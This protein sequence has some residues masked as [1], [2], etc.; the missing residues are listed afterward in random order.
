MCRAHAPSIRFFRQC[1]CMCSWSQMRLVCERVCV[2]VV[3]NQP[4]KLNKLH[5]L[6]HSGYYQ[7]AYDPNIIFMIE[8]MEAHVYCFNCHKIRLLTVISMR[9]EANPAIKALK[10]T[11]CVCVYVVYGLSNGAEVTTATLTIMFSQSPTVRLVIS[12]PNA[13]CAER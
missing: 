1:E 12:S 9:C 8:F 7:I 5:S 3:L 13:E 4:L 11:P 10:G 2:C 6:F